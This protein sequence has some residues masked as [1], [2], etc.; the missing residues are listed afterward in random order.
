M[1][2]ART[3]TNG[4][5]QRSDTRREEI[6]RAASTLFSTRGYQATSV[7]DIARELDLQGG[8]LYS[9]VASKEDM[10]WEIVSRAADAFLA[11]V[12]PIAATRE[13]APARLTSMIVAH[14]EIVVARLSQATV[15]FQDWRHL[16]DDRRNEIIRRRD[17]YEA[18]YRQ[19]IA[20]GIAAGDLRNIDPKLAAI[21]MLSALNGLPGWYRNDG[22]WSSS[23]LASGY[24]DLLLAGLLGGP[25][26]DE[27]AR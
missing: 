17:A 21:A 14:I 12:R 1:P 15:F 27:K 19:V 5:L 26:G 4:Q 23:D 6:Y 2:V 11:A 22:P 8:S 10:L 16:G 18:L 13:P 3:E 9:H 7:R 24:A 25:H 20:D